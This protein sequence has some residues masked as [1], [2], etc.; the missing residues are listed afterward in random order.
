MGQVALQMKIIPE[1][2][3]NIEEIIEKIKHMEGISSIKEVPIAFGLKLLEAIF[4]FDD[5]KGANTDELENKIK[6]IDGVSS[7][8]SGDVSLI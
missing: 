3:A 1:Q 4:V 7:V 5:R 8:E 2:E 6:E